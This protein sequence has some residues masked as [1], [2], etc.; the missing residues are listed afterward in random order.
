M[1]NLLKK[2]NRGT[3]LPKETSNVK[4][5][6]RT[7]D[8]LKQRLAHKKKVINAIHVMHVLHDSML[9]RLVLT[10]RNT[11]S[12]ISPVCALPGVHVDDPGTHG[13]LEACPGLTEIE[14]GTNK[15]SGSMRYIRHK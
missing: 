4:P 6:Y 7:F 10:C 5:D 14:L 2:T 3:I 12:A 11:N 8:F 15:I 1:K 9:Q 13:T